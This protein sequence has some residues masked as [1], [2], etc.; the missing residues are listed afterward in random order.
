MTDAASTPRVFISYSSSDRPFV[1]RLAS[2]LKRLGVAVWWDQWAIRVGDSISEKV[3]DGISGAAWLAVVLS[4]RSVASAW[5]QRELGAAFV[6]ELERRQIFVLPLLYEECDIPLLLRDK[7]YADFRASYQDGLDAVLERLEAPLDRSTLRE[8][9]SQSSGRIR[10]AWNGIPQ[11]GRPAYSDQ[12]ISSLRAESEEERLAALTA[13]CELQHRDV[14][15]F[16]SQGLRDKSDAV[17]R[18]S[19]H[20]TGKL[21]VQEHRAVV[22]GLLSDGSPMVRAAARAAFQQLGGRL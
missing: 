15:L 20:Y 17:R 19:V 13:L 14:P 22:A 4:P 21:G 9:L 1:A 10:I 11:L 8:L 12:L 3:Q 16:L 18:L 5:V 6:T 2:D 7:L